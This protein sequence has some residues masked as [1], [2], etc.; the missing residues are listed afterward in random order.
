ML[1]IPFFIFL[2]FCFSLFSK[3]L[4]KTNLSEEPILLSNLPPDETIK[5]KRS[6][7]L[8]IPFESLENLSKGGFYIINDLDIKSKKEWSF[9]FRELVINMVKQTNQGVLKNLANSLSLSYSNDTDL[10]ALQSKILNHLEAS[11]SSKKESIQ[12]KKIFPNIPNSGIILKNADILESY[13]EKVENSEEK[14][15]KLFGN[16][17]IFFQESTIYANQ[18]ILNTSSKQ[19]F[20]QDQVFLHANQINA[21]ADRLILDIEKKTGFALK[22][23]GNIDSN[24][25]TGE[26]LK[27]NSD[28]HVTVEKA[29]ITFTSNKNPEYVITADSF[30]Y[31]GNQNMILENIIMYVHNQPFFYFPFFMQDPFGT[32]VEMYFGNTRRE[33]YYLLM[34]LSLKIPL[35]K[36]LDLEFNTY[37]KIGT[38]FRIKNSNDFLWSYYELDFA[39]SRYLFNENIPSATLLRYT[40][41]TTDRL[42][43]DVRYRYKINYN[44]KLS[45]QDPDQSLLK[46]TLYWDINYSS[47]P[48]FTSDL[49]RN[50]PKLDLFD[51]IGSST[52]EGFYVNT[53]Y[54]RRRYL[55]EY[56][57][58]IKQ[59][60]F[61]L[62][63][64]WE[65]ANRE[66]KSVLDKA[67][68]ERWD[69]ALDYVVLPYMK[70]TYQDTIDPVPSDDE[71]RK[72]GF[73]YLNLNYNL[74]ADVSIREYYERVLPYNFE[75]NE[76][77]FNFLGALSRRWLWNTQG[78]AF[79]IFDFQYFST[80]QF[81]YK[82]KW[83]GEEL[84]EVYINQNKDNTYYQVAF[85]QEAVFNFPT[86]KIKKKWHKSYEIDSMFPT[87]NFK[88]NHRIKK[89]S[90]LKNKEV[91]DFNFSEF[92]DH[93]FRASS[94]V[95]WP[96]YGLFLIPYLNGSHIGNVTLNYNLIPDLQ[97]ST[98]SDFFN[99]SRFININGSWVYRGAYRN[100]WVYSSELLVDFYDEKESK[101]YT[102]ITQNSFSTTFKFEDFFKEMKDFLLLDQ[103]HAT[104]TWNYYFENINYLLDTMTFQWLFRFNVV[105]YWQFDVAFNSLN[106]QAFL[107][108]K[109]KSNEF[110]VNQVNF[111]QD[112]AASL[113]FLGSD[114]LKSSLFKIQRINFSLVH[115]L[116]SWYV[117]LDYSVYPVVLPSQSGALK[118][119][120]F[121]Q[122]I[123][124]E[125]NFKPEHYP[126]K[127]NSQLF[128]PWNR[129]VRPSVFENF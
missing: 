116:E 17:E 88:F 73:G 29:A 120:Y 35:F 33:G 59:F 30:D 121:D 63:N 1:K 72:R 92:A 106:N 4:E 19:I 6:Q 49:E 37:E 95:V 3:S 105:K 21:H 62:R 40:F 122:K 96:W 89:R 77:D 2:F 11:D 48:F 34:S 107:Y 81:N 78:D 79:P 113:G 83:G 12:K 57:I 98:F 47:D 60:G 52:Q 54:N 67:S 124:F 70:F 85:N 44:H 25:Y 51:L 129:D 108:F 32:G 71:K 22:I 8:I 69:N 110:G 104:Y 14:I 97:D 112:I 123:S 84:G 90:V 16:I 66:N 7:N 103:L 5:K 64:Q 10:L 93:N 55:V 58:G 111:F 23:K 45:L 102:Q 26:L 94:T 126:N 41:H 9:N 117:R 42:D 65:Y 87:L 53:P 75:R 39:F 13:G 128:S 127:Q 20:F 15:I 56:H 86:T 50:L 125:I 43:Q 80:F 91:L 119:F 68:Y 27:I 114:Q 115:D 28:A 74:S 101:V 24:Y 109:E 82:K 38:Y 100:L 76:N 18:A 36:Q 118:G 46:N 99:E 61:Q 31:F